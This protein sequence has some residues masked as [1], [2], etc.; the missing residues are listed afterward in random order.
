MGDARLRSS[1]AL[2]NVTKVTH[3][4]YGYL[5]PKQLVGLRF[6]DITSHPESL[7]NNCKRRSRM[8]LNYQHKDNS[9][10]TACL[11]NQTVFCSSVNEN[12]EIVTFCQLA[13]HN[14]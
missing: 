10:Q 7:V 3:D 6:D 8:Q 2:C 9:K 4:T 12:F 1:L 11:E 13:S 5:N 14:I